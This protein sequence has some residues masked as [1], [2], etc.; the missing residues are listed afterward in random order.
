MT[1]RYRTP[2][3]QPIAAGLAAIVVVACGTGEA[4]RT[5]E[6]QDTA[7]DR[8]V[9]EAPAIV[10]ERGDTMAGTAGPGIGDGDG[11]AADGAV[12]PDEPVS[13][14]P[15]VRSP[16]ARSTG[17]ADRSPVGGGSQP[18][19]PGAAASTDAILEATARTYE[20]VRSL[21]A[22]FEQE[23]QNPLL[24]RTTRSQGTLY[25]RQPDRF[26]MR[27]SDPAGD[28]IVGDG[29]YFWIY[30][31]SVDPQQVIRAEG[32]PQGLD[33]HA[34]F[35]GDPVRR[36]AATSH[37]SETVRGRSAHVMTLVPR[38]PLGYRSLKVW[39]DAEDH[40]VRRFELTEEN[41]NTR[42]FELDDV[43]V[44]PTLPDYLF[45]FTPP[46]GA[47]VIQR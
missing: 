42:R 30:Y 22:D 11:D 46:A 7:T 18:S 1:A 8:P 12:A 45:E 13:D 47:Q 6:I 38:E 37:G 40:L 39:I 2:V 5:A 43:L 44:N 17:G 41:G 33:L 34:Q 15:A 35:I 31:P 21:Q 27:F 36:F 28:V 20:R 29:R 3:G 25:Q 16:G 14:G 26:L 23:M 19:Q 9:V 32:G 24:G 4:D 10:A